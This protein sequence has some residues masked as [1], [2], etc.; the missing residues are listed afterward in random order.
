MIIDPEYLQ[1]AQNTM[2]IKLIRRRSGTKLSKLEIFQNMSCKQQQVMF[3]NLSLW[4]LSLRHYQYCWYVGIRFWTSITGICSSVLWSASRV[5]NRQGS[6][7]FLIW[8]NLKIINVI[9]FKTLLKYI[10]DLLIFKNL[11]QNF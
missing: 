6:I 1:F 3:I 4:P 9:I 10:S 7:E 5:I 11:C 8:K 2:G